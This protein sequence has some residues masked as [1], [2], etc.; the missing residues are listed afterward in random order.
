LGFRLT[1]IQLSIIL[2]TFIPLSKIKNIITNPLAEMFIVLLCALAVEWLILPFSKSPFIIAVPIC[3][4]LATIVLSHR[5]RK[6]S[7]KDIG[8]RFDNFAQCWRILILPMLAFFVFLTVLG[9]YLGSLRLNDIFSQA[10]FRKYAWLF[11]WGLIQQHALQAFFNRRAQ[12]IWGKGFSSVFVAASIFAL[13]HL[14]NFWLMVATFFGGLMWAAVYQRVPNLF[15]LALSHGIMSGA[16]VMT[17][18]RAALH[19]MR[20]GYNY[21]NL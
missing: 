18:P 8:Y 20:V 14:P 2:Q 7:L 15:V 9:W 5:G 12:E 21:F 16:L 1:Q 10:F 6:E 19:G 13:L 11:L 4:A 3:I 17:M